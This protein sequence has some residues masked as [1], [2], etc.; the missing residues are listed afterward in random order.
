MLQLE[1]DPNEPQPRTGFVERRRQPDRRR[2]NILAATFPPKEET[3]NEERQP[4]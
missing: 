2:S 4:A 3:H 1:I